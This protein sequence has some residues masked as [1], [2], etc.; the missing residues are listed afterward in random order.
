MIS[1]PYIYLLL[2]M[3]LYQ[4]SVPLFLDGLKSDSY[5]NNLP[6]QNMVSRCSVT[7][8]GCS[9]DYIHYIFE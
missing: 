9:V 6:I 8:G 4:R 5:F 7:G 3:R 1:D 2:I